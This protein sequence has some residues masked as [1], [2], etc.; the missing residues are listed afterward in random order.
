MTN[1]EIS[2]NSG[3]IEIENF[4]ESDSISL[5]TQSG[6]IA[7]KGTPA[8]STSIISQSGDVDIKISERLFRDVKAT[9]I[10]GKIS[11]VDDKTK[12]REFTN[13]NGFGRIEIVTSSGNIYIR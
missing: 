13:E 6:K 11:G 12:N 1:L 8:N 9:N 3:D 5:I 2:S 4:G 7:L 10:S